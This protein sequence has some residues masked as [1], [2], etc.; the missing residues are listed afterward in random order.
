M[1]DKAKK[2]LVLSSG[3][4]APGMNA[5]IRSVVRTALYN[6]FEVYGAVGG[7]QG[8]LDKKIIAMNNRF[9]GNCIQK[10]GTILKTG[11]CQE[12]FQHEVRVKAAQIIN[13]QNFSAMIV[14]GGNGSFNG[15]RL[16]ADI[17]KI[18]TIG[19]PCTIDNDIYG[20]EYTIGF[21]TACNTA[22]DAIDK[23]RDTAFSH[24]RN[25]LIEVMGRKSGFIAV[26]VG[27]AGG[28]EYIL[29]PEYPTSSADLAAKI[30]RQNHTKQASIMVMTEGDTPGSSIHFAAELKELTGIDFKVCI[31][32]HTQ[33]GGSPSVR[34][35]TVASIM[36]AEAVKAVVNGS[37]NKMLAI[38]SG[39]LVFKDFPP[40]DKPS[41]NFHDQELL[42]INS[43]LCDISD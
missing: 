22:L 7:Y 36:G 16:L 30:K 9:V 28:A 4:D 38:E 42:K 27:I 31:L 41:R 3:G 21:D 39:A 24:N 23:I 8:I 33:R 11:R 32:G 43:I 17:A 15:A 20:T 25:F 13:E 19:I 26:E 37:S 34:D 2:L 29:I 35:R 12:F 10:G 14:L 18:Q 40:E 5:A 1:I 6:N